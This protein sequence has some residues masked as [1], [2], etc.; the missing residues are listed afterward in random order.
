MVQEWVWPFLKI[1][2]RPP[3]CACVWG[4][5]SSGSF[6]SCGEEVEAVPFHNWSLFLLH[7]DFLFY[8]IMMIFNSLS[9]KGISWLVAQNLKAD[10][11]LAQPKK[12]KKTRRIEIDHGLVK[13]LVQKF[14]PL[15]NYCGLVALMICLFK[16]GFAQKSLPDR[17]TDISQL[18][19]EKIW[20]VF[21]PS[22]QV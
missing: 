15:L 4:A 13:M 5:G 12:K 20:L 7:A 10:M 18:K 19:L 21:C 1:I 17:L 6:S 2:F 11:K 14:P 9:S 22:T 16:C 3:L 8:F